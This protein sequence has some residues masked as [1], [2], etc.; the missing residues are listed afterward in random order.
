MQ[1][2]ADILLRV[3]LDLGVAKHPAGTD[4]TPVLP[5]DPATLFRIRDAVQRARAEFYADFPDATFRRNAIDLL[6]GP[7]GGGV[8]VRSETS[9]AIT[10]A[11][12]GATTSFVSAVAHGLSTGMTVRLS[13]F[14]ADVPLT[15]EKRVTVLTATTFSVA[16]ATTTISTVGRVTILG[17]QVSDPSSYLLPADWMGPPQGN[18]IFSGV[19]GGSGVLTTMD[20]V[21]QAHAQD[22]SGRVGFP[23][24]VACERETNAQPG[25]IARW[26][27]RV[28]P[29]PDQAYTVTLRGRRFA[30]P[31]DDT[32]VEPSGHQEAIA[33]YATAYLV[34]KGLISTGVAP[35]AAVA[36][37]AAW[38]ARVRAEEDKSSPRS[39]GRSLPARVRRDNQ[40]PL[41]TV[42]ATNPYSP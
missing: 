38:I 5:D 22:T 35:D 1:T 6:I 19:R 10:S 29:N 40:Y 12:A 2:F 17:G 20:R 3:A 31:F 26:T 13:G 16:V 42:Q 14:V 9:L 4:N 30:A 23:S 36:T 34:V 7:D 15:G 41:P 39:L 25:E 28:Y 21:R 27:L 32:D 37:K 11:T 33:A 24:L 18:L 8:L